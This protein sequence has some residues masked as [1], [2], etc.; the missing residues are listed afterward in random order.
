MPCGLQIRINSKVNAS[1]IEPTHKNGY[2]V[3]RQTD[4]KRLT[5]AR[6]YNGTG[7]Q[8]RYELQG[9]IRRYVSYS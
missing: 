5:L 3:Y 4:V 9:K 6:K 8:S 7:V 1:I 2:V